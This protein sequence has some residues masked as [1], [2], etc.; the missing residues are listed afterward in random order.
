MYK[1]ISD[2]RLC[3]HTDL[4]PVLDLG[5]QA[6]T[7]IF[8]KTADVD[9]PAGPLAL[10]KCAR[11]GLVQLAHNYDLSM[12]YGDTYGYRSG[13]NQS[14][15]RHLRQKVSGIEST[16]SLKSGDLVIDIGSNDGTL[17]GSYTTPGL[18]RL[19]IDPSG[20]KF[21]QYYPAGAELIPEFFSAD[22]IRRHAGPAKARVVTSIAM[23]YDLERPLDFVEQV[24][25]VLADDGVWVFEQSYL[26]SMVSTHSYDTVCHEHLEYYTLKQI[27]FIANKLGLKIVD[28]ALNDVNGGSFSLAV[29]KQNSPYPEAH[30]KVSRLLSE[31]QSQG[32]DTTVPLENLNAAMHRHRDEL[33]ELL[34]SVSRDGKKVFGY[35]ASTKGNVLLQFCGINRKHLPCIA[36]VNE[37]K[38]GAF[39]PGTKIP[40][41]S[42]AEARFQK[43]DYFMV[44][45]WH[46]RQGIV[47]RERAYMSGGGSLIFPLPS[48]EVV[49]EPVVITS[50]VHRA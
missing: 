13:L 16:V 45:P 42:E 48:L 31:E 49:S 1:Q 50:S 30:A 11:C 37:D 25:A 44:L 40:I 47:E 46:F 12:L 9:V 36:E 35:G 19:G 8:P 14:M 5:V 22:S 32:Y 27:V 7:G 2:C 15:V 33:Q 21:Q 39:T 26:P 18:R 38:F 28:V 17:L 34:E 23:F 3:F 41:V 29:A 10:V 6:L 43:P 4:I 24:M 20:Q